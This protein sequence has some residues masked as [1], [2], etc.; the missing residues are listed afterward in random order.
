MLAKH[1][2][3]LGQYWSASERESDFVTVSSDMLLFILFE[4]WVSRPRAVQ[5]SSDIARWVKSHE[6]QLFILP[7]ATQSW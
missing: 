2:Y 6:S 5:M 1:P 4:P 3:A 7:S